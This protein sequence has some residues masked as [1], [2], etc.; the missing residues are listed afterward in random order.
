MILFSAEDSS[1]R[2]YELTEE[3]RKRLI[4]K[5]NDDQ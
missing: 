2:L 1:E 5:K 3:Y 4:D